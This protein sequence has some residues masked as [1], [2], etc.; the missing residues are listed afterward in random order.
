MQMYEYEL[1][2]IKTRQPTADLMYMLGKIP[3]EGAEAFQH[4]LKH[5]YHDKPLDTD[6]IV[7]ELGDVL[8]Y[9]AN[10]ASMLGVTLEVVAE[11][12][13]AKLRQRHGETYNPAHYAK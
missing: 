11:G 3:V 5:I 8:W 9:V 10:A 12:N 4:L 13:V 2:A 7:D 6:A 1:E